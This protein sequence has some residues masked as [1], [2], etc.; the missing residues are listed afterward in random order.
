M[1]HNSQADA[2]QFGNK[3]DNASYIER[4]GAYALL[5]NNEQHLAVV[6]SSTQWLL[7]GGGIEQGED[8]QEALKREV[9]EEIGLDVKVGAFLGCANQYCYSKKRDK[10]YNKQCFYH[11]VTDLGAAPCVAE[12]ELLW[13][14]V[15]DV[16]GNLGHDSHRWVIERYLAHNAASK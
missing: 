15:D 12:F 2:L 4:P 9:M 16:L 6:A 11:L 5:F 14:P 10:Y 8:Q 3:V 7:P 1:N 13:R